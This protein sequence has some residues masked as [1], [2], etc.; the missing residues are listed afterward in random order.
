MKGDEGTAQMFGEMFRNVFGWS[1]TRPSALDPQLYDQLFQMYIADEGQLGIRSWFQQKNPAAYQAMTATMLESARKGYW[2]PSAAQLKS[3]AQ[4]HAEVT[5]Q[6]GAACTD[7]VCNNLQLQE[8]VSGKL[9]P[10]A[11]Q[12]YNRQMSLVKNTSAGAKAMVLEKQGTHADLNDSSDTNGDSTHSLIIVS[13]VLI[14][15]IVAIV[16]L[17]LK[18]GNRR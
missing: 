15:L 6:S 13:I 17:R 8:F 3:L 5:Q 11:R 10:D 9:A 12:S 16:A 18:H 14:F 1:V 2:M 7:F 4:L